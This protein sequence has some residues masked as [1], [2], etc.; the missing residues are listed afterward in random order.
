MSYHFLRDVFQDST[1][2]GAREAFYIVLLTWRR[3]LAVTVARSVK[4][5]IAQASPVA[6]PPRSSRTAARCFF[7]PDA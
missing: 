4:F 7:S 3:A 2:D 1:T 5:D 6:S